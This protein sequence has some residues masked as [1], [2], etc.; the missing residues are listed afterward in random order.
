MKLTYSAITILYLLL[1]VPSQAQKLDWSEAQKVKE[2][3]IYTEVIGSWNGSYY[4]VR[5]NKKNN[6]TFIIEKYNQR[7]LLNKKFQFDLSKDI[8][9]EKIVLIN[10]KLII[11]SVLH[12]NEKDKYKLLANVFSEDLN[13]VVNDQ[14]LCN[15]SYRASGKKTFFVTRDNFTDR[16]LV[17]YPEKTEN[18]KLTFKFNVFN[19][20]LENM[21][22]GCFNINP[23][24]EF[25]I[26]QYQIADSNI[27]VTF[28]VGKPLIN[29]PTEN[30][31]YLLSYN[32]EKNQQTTYSFFDDTTRFS[33]IL[34]K[35]NS[36]D[37]SF[38]CS[39]FY[40]DYL[41]DEYQGIGY[42]K[43]FT[44]KD[45][46][47]FQK[48]PFTGSLVSGIVGKS[49]KSEGLKA[50]Y[51]K[52]IVPRNDGGFV[53]IGEYYSI[54]R[55]VYNDYFTNANSYERYY[56]QYSDLI[57]LSVNPDGTLDWNKIIRKEQVS[58]GD[59][60]YYSSFTTG[61]LKEAIVILF[62]DISRSHTNLLY[63]QVDL[64]G[65]IENNILVNGNLFKGSLI[66]KLGKQVSKN[67]ILI[68]GFENKNGFLFARITF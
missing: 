51:P 41:K 35:Y 11:F 59:D 47:F 30:K 60:G 43:V 52:N 9:I 49:T 62:N 15:T 22:E 36:Q 13:L 57:L 7:L 40:S 38:V 39:G 45:S 3:I 50:F 27:M 1:L 29:K 55:E 33:N 48:V 19:Q 16:I 6:Q 18:D 23:G 37:T 2:K 65:N 54:H 68:P 17:V 12:D 5:Y 21:D 66:P 28:K 31:Y 64:L 56:Y 14:T 32:L 46:V 44:L 20:N 4:F 26:E 58:M 63:N 53:F 61:N 25:N 8:S 67:E 34:L 24:K 10:G 42:L